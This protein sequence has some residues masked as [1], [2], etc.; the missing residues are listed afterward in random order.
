[1]GYFRRDRGVF[2]ALFDTSAIVPGFNAS[3]H[4]PS[5]DPPKEVCV[6]RYLAGAAAAPARAKAFRDSPDLQ[7]KMKEVGVVD[8]PEIRF[9]T[10]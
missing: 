10:D 3:G 8:R 4:F 7:A 1:M 2:D 6:S 9:L 5:W